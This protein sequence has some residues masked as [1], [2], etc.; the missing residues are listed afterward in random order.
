MIVNYTLKEKCAYIKTRF[1]VAIKRSRISESTRTDCSRT[2][3]E[4]IQPCDSVGSQIQVD[5]LME[6]AKTM[7]T[8]GTYHENIVNLQGVAYETDFST[9]RL[10]GVT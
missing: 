10:S 4:E 7:Y 3:D 6:E 5:Q 9:G 2:L 8:I 1:T